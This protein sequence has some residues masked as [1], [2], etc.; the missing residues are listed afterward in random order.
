MA[1]GS[2]SFEVCNVV[3]VFRVCRYFILLAFLCRFLFT[4][5]SAFIYRVFKSET[6]FKK[7][8]S[9]VQAHSIVRNI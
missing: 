4:P 6:A 1:F 7:T 3:F 8:S 5:N 2:F 9:N